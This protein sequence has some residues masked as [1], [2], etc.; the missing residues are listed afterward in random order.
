MNISPTH[1]CTMTQTEPTTQP[2]IKASTKKAPAKKVPAKKV[3]VKKAVA[4]K[5]VAK[6]APVKPTPALAPTPAP[7]AAAKK[8]VAKPAKPKKPAKVK[9]IR[10][11]FTMPEADFAII[12][13][14]KLRAIEWKQP[15]KKSEVLRA[16]L[17][18][19]GAL[20]DAQ[21]KK[22]LSGLSPVKKGRPNKAG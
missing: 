14:I 21:V 20:P 16:A 5:V 10:D 17:Y 11:S 18:A 15:V 6:K 3:A 2:A 8:P 7:K 4:K 1:H 13:R 22:L 19:L 9:V 12:D